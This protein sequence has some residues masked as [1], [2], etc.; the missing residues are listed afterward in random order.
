MEHLQDVSVIQHLQDVSVIPRG[1]AQS[2]RER[3]EPR[4]DLVRLRGLAGS[5]DTIVQRV[6]AQRQPGFPADEVE[7]MRTPADR[8]RAAHTWLGLGS[9]LA[10]PDPDPNPNPNPNPNP[11]IPQQDSGC[12]AWLRKELK[13]TYSRMLPLPRSRTIASNRSLGRRTSESPAHRSF[14]RKDVFSRAHEAMLP[15]TTVSV[16]TLATQEYVRPQRSSSAATSAPHCSRRSNC[17]MQGSLHALGPSARSDAWSQPVGRKTLRA[18]LTEA[19]PIG[20]RCP[21]AVS[22]SLSPR[23]MTTNTSKAVSG[24]S[25]KVFAID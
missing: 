6:V 14:Q 10:N 22:C 18:A 12:E 24:L 7:H 19:A 9:G 23:L 11:K 15:C 13:G 2:A 20:Y 25:R 4:C 1:V 21:F 17:A 5:L 8:C 3:C 16:R